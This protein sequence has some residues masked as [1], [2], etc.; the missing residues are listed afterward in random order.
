[1]T[2]CK[3]LVPRGN[4]QDVRKSASSSLCDL[5]KRVDTLEI[6]PQGGVTFNYE[7]TTSLSGDPTSGHVGFDSLTLASITEARVS[8]TTLSGNDISGFMIDMRAGDVLVL[9][10]A[11]APSGTV[12]FELTGTPVD[13]GTYF[14]IAVTEAAVT[15]TALPAANNN[16]VELTLIYARVID[17]VQLENR[18]AIDSHPMSAI[19]GLV[20][21]QNRQD[22]ALAD[23]ESNVSDPHDVQH[24]QLGGVGVDQ[25]HSREHTHD[26]T[27][28][29]GGSIAHAS[30]TGQTTDDHHPQVH[31][32]SSHTNI[33]E[34]D[35]HSRTHPLYS[36]NQS[37]VDS[38]G[39][40][41]IKQGLF[42]NLANTKFEIDYRTKSL[43]YVNG[44][45]YYPQEMVFQDGWLTV[46]NQVTTDYPAPVTVG[47]PAFVYA[48]LDPTAQTSVKQIIFGNRYTWGLTGYMGGYRVY[49]IS[50]NHY[51]VFS[52]LDPLGTPIVTQ[53]S[54]FVSDTTGWVNLA[55][56]AALVGV[57]AVIDLV[58]VVNE[59]SPTPTTWNGDW[60]YETPNNAG[61]PATG[62][63]S[64]ANNQLDQLR[65]HKND[66][67]GGDRS[68]E[69]LAL[70]NGDIVEAGGIRWSIQNNSD[71]GAYVVLT[72]A[73]ATQITPDGVTTFTFE[74][75]VATPITRMEDVNYWLTN[76]NGQVQGLYIEDGEYTS[77][78]PNNNAYGTD[79]YIVEATISDHW[80]V[81]G[82]PSGAVSGGSGDSFVPDLFTGAGTSGYVPDPITSDGKIMDDSGNWVP[83]T[84]TK[85]E[86]FPSGLLDGGA[87]NIVGG[88]DVQVIAGAAIIMDSYT[89]PIEQP[90]FTLLSWDNLQE[91]I[92]GAATPSIIH[93]CMT[94]TG[95]TVGAPIAGTN[96][97][98][99]VQHT[100]PPTPAQKRQQVYLGYVVYNGTEWQDIS[101]PSVIN[102]TA[103]TL[104]DLLNDVG[105]SSVIQ[106]GGKVTEQ[107]VPVFNLDMEE[108]IVWQQNVNWH[109]SKL[110]PHRETVLAKPNAQF[111]YTN[112]DFSTITAPTPTVDPTLWDNNGTVESVSGGSKA[113]TIQRLYLDPD[114]SLWI[115]YGQEVYANYVDAVVNIGTDTSD[116]SIPAYLDNESILLG[117]IISER[118]KTDWTPSAAR[119]IPVIERSSSGASTAPT[120]FDQLTDTPA[121]KVS[122]AKRVV[123]VNDAGDQL[124][125]SEIY[126]VEASG[127]VGIGIALPAAH[128]HVHSTGSSTNLRISDGS[129]GFA[130]TSLFG[131]SALIN[132]DSTIDMYPFN[133]AKGRWSAN[134]LYIGGGVN[135]AYPL[136]VA[137]DCNLI[138]GVY[139]IDGTPIGQYSEG[140]WIPN[141]SNKSSGNYS[142]N[143]NKG[144][145]SRIGN[146]VTVKG[147]FYFTSF[148]GSAETEVIFSGLPFNVMETS[149][150][151]PFFGMANG[152][153]TPLTGL[154]MNQVIGGDDTGN[155][156]TSSAFHQV[157]IFGVE[158]SKTYKHMSYLGTNDI[159]SPDTMNFSKFKHFDSTTGFA[160]NLTYRTD[161]P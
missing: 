58:C 62:E 79:I 125:Y 21:D 116:A 114:R 109:T 139:R 7:Y 98:Q 140:T 75:V 141:C 136:E 69:L 108:A 103:H 70:S 160:I 31:D 73:P 55:T 133:L 59:P 131:G 44:G 10:E 110:D 83:R 137:G 15:G 106:S 96:L 52:V 40:P 20:A 129:G 80:D 84:G 152:I 74:T 104:N 99:I 111:K 153:L 38:S 34:N 3:Y 143:D 16:P 27:P 94:D 54:D 118:T 158:G 45:T 154:Q 48:G 86:S 97:G 2:D 93:I 9:Y 43:I 66:N 138:G 50:G 47:I 68:V 76:G 36:D 122:S 128:L 81:I 65:V 146:E 101:A 29:E 77:I 57:G 117:Y 134:G 119:F 157:T 126:H 151:A 28:E 60:D 12:V 64:H 23:H 150:N 132:S 147:I 39:V 71:A 14:T 56:P 130:L 92:V 78:V 100:S 72:V 11:V 115:L 25:H 89:N 8:K 159:V 124:I 88:T 6:A 155:P 49:T 161:D 113:A 32:H 5:D 17:H 121:D 41:A 87:I 18:D 123:S 33:G 24:G 61:V 26:G 30:T 127:R 91:L 145:W 105:G 37:D 85:A 142:S 67:G 22:Q 144:I 46:A 149:V 112:R 82:M 4:L 95:T 102:A 19:T 156:N 148:G 13:N 53:V 120:T 107:S 90:T 135:A 63:I 51:T 1:M 42:R 35:H